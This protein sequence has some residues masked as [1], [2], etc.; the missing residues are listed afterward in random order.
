MRQMGFGFGKLAIVATLAI[1][2]GAA[3]MMVSSTASAAVCTG[4]NPGGTAT[5][6][7][8]SL[9]IG[10]P[11]ILPGINY[12][13]TT[14][15]VLGSNPGNAE[16]AFAQSLLTGAALLDKSDDSGSGTVNGIRFTVTASGNT[17][18]WTL[19]WE[20]VN[21]GAPQNLPVQLDLVVVLKASND[22]AAYLFD[23]VELTA[24]P[25][26]GSG[27]FAVTFDPNRQGIFPGLS[28]LSLYGANFASP[29]DPNPPAVPE[30]A[31][32]ALFGAALAGLGVSLRRRR[33]QG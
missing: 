2:A 9:T 32:L 6:A 18:S 15:S 31:T 12:S 5:T 7:D 23:D 13:P 33:R 29:P 14:C 3:P 19:S 17:G 28:H 26:S 21:G 30:P 8:V 22:A 11:V 24:D 20:D 16:T 4:V 1:G 27:S 25:L 10:P